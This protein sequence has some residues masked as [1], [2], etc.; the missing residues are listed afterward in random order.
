MFNPISWI[1]DLFTQEEPQSKTSKPKVYLDLD[2]VHQVQSAIKDK[3]SSRRICEIFDI[4]SSHLSKIKHGQHHLLKATST[5]EPAII[6]EL[7]NVVPEDNHMDKLD[8]SFN[9]QLNKSSHKEHVHLSSE[10][11]VAIEQIL[12]LTPKVTHKEIK[13]TYQC[14]QSSLNRIVAGKHVKSS[15]KYK[16]TILKAALLPKG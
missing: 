4:S 13:A 6:D 2:Q 15:E 16:A 8:K 7:L 10:E 11:V 1:V 5:K 12:L 3:V 14:G 9:K